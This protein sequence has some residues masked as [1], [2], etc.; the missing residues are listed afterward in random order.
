MKNTLELYERFLQILDDT[1]L[2]LEYEYSNSFSLFDDYCGTVVAD[3]NSVLKGTK[4]SVRGY[5][6]CKIKRLI[7][8]GWTLQVAIQFNRTNSGVFTRN[9]INFE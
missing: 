7:W 6:N 4:V 1:V 8:M 5:K 2:D 3:M 9:E